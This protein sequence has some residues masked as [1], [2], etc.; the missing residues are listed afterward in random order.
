[1]QYFN[2]YRRL[3]PARLFSVTLYLQHCELLYILHRNQLANV[4]GWSL[5]L[6][7]L[8]LRSECHLLHFSLCL[9]GVELLSHCHCI[10]THSHCWFVMVTAFM[11]QVEETRVHYPV[12]QRQKPTE[13]MTWNGHSFLSCRWHSRQSGEQGEV[14]KHGTNNDK[15]T[16]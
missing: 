3:E 7:P 16:S 14:K 10:P 9:H 5:S 1:M 15:N 6:L 13:M 12:P 11:S 2:K 4:I 8:I